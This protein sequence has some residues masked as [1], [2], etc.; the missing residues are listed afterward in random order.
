MSDGAAR[1]PASDDDAQAEHQIQASLQHATEN[2]FS[3]LYPEEY[4]HAMKGTED[5]I[6]TSTLDALH[7]EVQPSVATP[8]SFPL[9]HSE[10]NGR[11]QHAD[12]SQS[13]TKVQN[14]IHFDVTQ[15]EAGSGSWKLDWEATH[16]SSSSSTVNA[17]GTNLQTSNGLKSSRFGSSSGS[18]EVFSTKARSNS[19]HRTTRTVD[20][21][22]VDFPVASQNLPTPTASLAVPNPWSTFAMSGLNS[23]A[24]LLLASFFSFGSRSSNKERIGAEEVEKS[25]D[26]KYCPFAEVE[27][28][29]KGQRGD[30][31]ELRHGDEDKTGVDET[32][33]YPIRNIQ[34]AGADSFV[35]A[36][37][38]PTS[39]VEGRADPGGDKSNDFFGGLHPSR[40]ILISDRNAPPQT[41]MLRKSRSDMAMVTWK[42]TGANT[43]PLSTQ[44]EPGKIQK[45]KKETKQI[46]SNNARMSQSESSCIR[47]CSRAEIHFLAEGIESL[48]KRYAYLN[49]LPSTARN[50]LLHCKR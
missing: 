32:S 25:D 13:A 1:A 34:D 38:A 5:G 18:D 19:P 27:T 23:S 14:G 47:D 39:D 41:E 12:T 26:P 9:K 22:T 4:G 35:I 20:E 15:E 40:M 29:K 17:G 46:T 48:K 3:L 42:A 6:G 31:L 33:Q 49:S 44:Q 43:M 2:I 21:A 11:F 50:G 7:S 30:R 45:A 24:K 10:Q 8:A 28:A 36:R 16:V 37:E